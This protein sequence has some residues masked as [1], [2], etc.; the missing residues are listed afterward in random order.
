[1]PKLTPFFQYSNARVLEMEEHR[2]LVTL[3]TAEQEESYRFYQRCCS[4]YADERSELLN[5]V[6]GMDLQLVLG[7]FGY[8]DFDQ[9]VYEAK[10]MDGEYLFDKDTPAQDMLN[11]EYPV[12][13]CVAMES[14][15]DRMGQVLTAVV[16]YVELREFNQK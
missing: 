12:I 7:A 14:D 8:T 16:E 10:D 1:M 13:A 6:N 4:E 11:L 15:H 3:M 9:S 2:D 5:A